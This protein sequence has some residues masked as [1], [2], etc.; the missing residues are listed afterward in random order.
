MVKRPAPVSVSVA[1]LEPSAVI[2]KAPAWIFT[3]PP[4]TSIL[5]A[6]VAFCDSSNLKVSVLSEY[7]IFFLPD[8]ATI[9]KS[10]LITLM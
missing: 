3:S 5:P 2:D 1:L 4:A 7:K 6:K 8:P 10:P 9:Y